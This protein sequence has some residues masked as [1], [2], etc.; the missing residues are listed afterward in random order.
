MIL[1]TVYS[2]LFLFFVIIDLIPMFRDKRWK[3]FWTYTVLL[4]TA[5]VLIFLIVLDIKIPSPTVPIK[6]MITALFGVSCY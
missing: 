5:Y 2:M 3:S 1:I 4:L 6:K